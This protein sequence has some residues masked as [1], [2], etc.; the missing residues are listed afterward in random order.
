MGDIRDAALAP[1]GRDRIDWAAGEMPVLRQIRE[2]FDKER[3]LDGFRI[4]PAP[5]N[6]TPAASPCT[7]RVRS[8]EVT[9]QRCGMRTKGNIGPLPGATLASRSKMAV[10]TASLMALSRPASGSRGR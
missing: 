2:R 3:P 6:P 7:I 4:A 10:S 9:P 5:R 1:G 8:A